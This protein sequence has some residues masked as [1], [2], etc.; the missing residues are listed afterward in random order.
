MFIECGSYR[1]RISNSTRRLQSFSFFIFFPLSNIALLS[2]QS[3]EHENGVL[4][5]AKM[6]ENLRM[7]RQGEGGQ[8]FSGASSRRTVAGSPPLAHTG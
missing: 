2:V 3:G 7:K 4:R 5:D 8:G 6:G 1:D